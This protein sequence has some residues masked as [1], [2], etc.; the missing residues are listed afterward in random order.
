[1]K[2]GAFIVVEGLDRVGKSSQCINLVQYLNEHGVTTVGKKF[3]DRTTETGI[4]I[5]R[6]LRKIEDM[7]D[8]EIHRLYA[9]NRKEV[10]DE[11]FELLESGKTIVCDRY[12][13]SGSAYTCAKG[14]ELDWA[15][16]YD[17]GIIKPDLIIY[18]TGDRELLVERLAATAAEA[19]ERY[20]QIDFLLKVNSLLE[21]I[22][23]GTKIF[24][25]KIVSARGTRE[26]VL[27]RI[28]EGLI[29]QLAT[30]TEHE[31]ESL[32]N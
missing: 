24:T 15:M 20:E 25:H 1:M 28:T 18:L 10:N 22:I 17:A 3:P 23:V 21:K 32:W 5:D 6:Y 16:E 31:I 8:E 7:S 12:A 26:E 4:R 2:R 19:L 11:F 29:D 9:D 13:M 14:Y 30:L 27:M